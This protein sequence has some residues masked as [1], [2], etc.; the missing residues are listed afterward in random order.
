MKGF[1]IALIEDVQEQ[2]AFG[3]WAFGKD[4]ME[5]HDGIEFMNAWN[6]LHGNELLLQSTGII[7]EDIKKMIELWRENDIPQ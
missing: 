6:D 7:S 3:L 1:V 4:L 2:D 5:I